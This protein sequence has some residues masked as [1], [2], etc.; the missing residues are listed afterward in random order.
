MNSSNEILKCIEKFKAKEQLIRLVQYLSFLTQALLKNTKYT[1]VT[2]KAKKLSGN[3]SI[4]RK[5]L[6]FGMPVQVIMNIISRSKS[7][8]KII[9]FI[10]D[11][12]SLLYYATDHLLYFYRVRLIS[13]KKNLKHIQM[14]DVIRNL[15]W[16]CL[17]VAK[18]VDYVKEIHSVQKK[19]Q[20]LSVSDTINYRNSDANERFCRLLQESD[21]LVLGIIASCLDLPVALYFL[22]PSK[23]NPILTG[24]LGSLSSIINLYQILKVSA[25]EIP[26]FSKKAIKN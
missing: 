16:V 15:A 7:K 1:S 4:V 24:A 26:L 23:I 19:I 2:L 5:V 9:K 13:W 14:V 11:L 18:I 6:R 22:D 8:M 10:R 25:N 21:L 12:F 3:L 20:K 17:L